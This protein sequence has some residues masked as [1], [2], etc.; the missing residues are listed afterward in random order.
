MLVAAPAT[1]ADAPYVEGDVIEIRGIVTDRAGNP[2]PGKTVSLE[3]YRKAFSFKPSDLGKTRKGLVE[4][5]T[6]SGEDGRYS[7]RWQWYDYF[8]RFELSVGD[9]GPDGYVV[10][11]RAD[12]SRR[13]L[14]G[15][16]VTV[17]F[18]VGDTPAASGAASSRPTTSTP[19]AATSPSPRPSQRAAAVT[20]SAQ[21]QI[22]QR[23]GEPDLVEHL[24]LPYGRETTWWYFELGRAYR[25]L[26]GDLRDELTFNPV[27]SD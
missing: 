14:R 20:S 24:D 2:L 19:P 27:A 17:S 10:L 13:I 16:P 6:T 11:E 5:S 12:L 18:I 23:Q 1:A 25:F 7:L 4:R 9:F 15:S 22:R 8:N 21:S 3:A 26:D